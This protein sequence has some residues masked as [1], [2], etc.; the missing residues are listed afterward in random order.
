MELPWMLP[1]SQSV[2]TS[3]LFSFATHPDLQTGLSAETLSHSTSGSALIGGTGRRPECKW[4]VQ[5]HGG[6]PDCDESPER[7]GCH[8]TPPSRT[9]R[10]S[11][12]Y[13]AAFRDDSPR[14][15]GV[16]PLHSCHSPMQAEV[17]RRNQ[18]TRRDSTSDSPQTGR[19]SEGRSE[20]DGPHVSPRQTARCLPLYLEKAHPQLPIGVL[21]RIAE[22]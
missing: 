1:V 6:C 17:C 21:P 20:S 13:D 8:P 11:T 10:F 16:R 9:E 4:R 18:E 12:R 3:E 14:I 2:S 19:S 22:S 7:C 5:Q 15:S